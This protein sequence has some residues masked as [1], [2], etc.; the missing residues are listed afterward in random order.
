[1]KG[2]KKRKM[3]IKYCHSCQE[4]IDFNLD[5]HHFENCQSETGRCAVCGEAMIEEKHQEPDMMGDFY[6]EIDIYCENGCDLDE[7]LKTDDFFDTQTNYGWILK[8]NKNYGSE[9]L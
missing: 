1:M 2:R 8:T 4:W 5:P 7:Y 6:D 3:Q 9:V